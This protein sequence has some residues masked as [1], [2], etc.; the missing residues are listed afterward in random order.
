ML[1][2]V[3]SSDVQLPLSVVQTRRKSVDQTLMSV[4][5]RNDPHDRLSV[6]LG[7]IDRLYDVMVLFSIVITAIHLHSTTV[8]WVT[9][10]GWVN[11]LT[12]TSH[13][14]KL[15]LPSLRVR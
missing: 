8:V 15:S 4:G 7:A 5:E 9:V 14:G 10:C 2:S 12:I 3:A 6:W 11:H 1:R 13:L